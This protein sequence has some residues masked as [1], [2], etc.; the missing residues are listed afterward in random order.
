MALM[1]YFNLTMVC[2]V[3]RQDQ[4]GAKK[5]SLGTRG[6]QQLELSIRQLHLAGLERTFSSHLAVITLVCLVLLIKDTVFVVS[7]HI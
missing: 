1:P 5:T 7:Y 3:R 2:L 4:V 6:Y